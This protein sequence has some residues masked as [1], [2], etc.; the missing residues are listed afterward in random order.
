[1]LVL[2]RSAAGASQSKKNE[3]GYASRRDR[4]VPV[5]SSARATG[6]PQWLANMGSAT[7]NVWLKNG[8]LTGRDT[9]GVPGW[10]RPEE[11]AN[12]PNLDL[13]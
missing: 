1:M 9:T 13:F 4:S 10:I 12:L 8:P 6:R 2:I 7:Q 3:S 11:L 5:A